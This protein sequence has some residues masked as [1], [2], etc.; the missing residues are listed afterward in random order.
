MQI[1]LDFE[2]KNLKVTRQLDVTQ[3]KLE[4][5]EGQ[6]VEAE[7]EAYFARFKAESVSFLF[8]VSSSSSL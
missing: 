2:G 3:N 6:K 1:R 8:F 4:T 5:V 7:K